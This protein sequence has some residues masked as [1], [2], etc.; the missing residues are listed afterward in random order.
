[1]RVWDELSYQEIAE[2]TG[3]SIGSLKMMFS[4]TISDLRRELPLAL[5]IVLII[6]SI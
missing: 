2:I 4:R 6:R 1:M 3:K 5:Y